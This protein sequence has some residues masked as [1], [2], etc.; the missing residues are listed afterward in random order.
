MQT[1]TLHTCTNIRASSTNVLRRWVTGRHNFKGSWWMY[2]GST[3]TTSSISWPS[4]WVAMTDLWQRSNCGTNLPFPLHTEV[5]VQL[6][7]PHTCGSGI[8]ITSHKLLKATS[9]LWDL[10]NS[11]SHPITPVCLRKHATRCPL[12]WLRVFYREEN[13]KR[14]KLEYCTHVNLKQLPKLLL[15]RVANVFVGRAPVL[16]MALY[17]GKNLGGEA[18]SSSAPTSRNLI[19]KVCHAKTNTNPV[20][21]WL[22][23][24][25][26]ST[27]FFSAS[28]LELGSSKHYKQWVPA[29]EDRPC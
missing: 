16:S 1:A 11:L 9:L 14:A 7:I 20:H 4:G 25:L 24:L 28:F 29:T 6:Y 27:L 18:F 10:E 19:W 5:K 23:K 8:G 21:H 15:Q 17:F 13:R 26:S 12:T 3:G 22:L 2:A